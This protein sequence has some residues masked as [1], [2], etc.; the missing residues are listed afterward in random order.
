MSSVVATIREGDVAV[1]E[2]DNPPVNALSQAV[3]AGLLA[4]VREADADARVRAIVIRCQGRTFIAGADISE[5]DQPPQSPHLPEVTEAI[6][7]CSKPVIAAIH[8]TA[9]GGGFE[10]ALA[11]HYR[12]A[13]LP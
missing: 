7:N 13:P 3:R 10:I 2:V 12:V 4:A 6:E 1:I 11:C 9:L 5:F 8:G